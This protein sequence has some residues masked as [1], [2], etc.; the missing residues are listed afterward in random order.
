M[1]WLALAALLVAAPAAAQPTVELIAAPQAYVPIVI[2]GAT[3][4]ARVALGFDKALLL[5][6][7]PAQAARLK[8]FPVIGK[9]TIKNAL[10]PGGEAVARGNLYGARIAGRPKTTVPTVWIDKAI[11][12]EADGIVSVF[13]LDAERVTVRQPA[14]PAG[15]RTYTLTRDGKGDPAVKLRVGGE[16]LTVALDLV[17]PETIM[18]ARAAAALEAA[19]LVRRSGA[20]GLWTP[21]PNV[22]L[23]F[24]RLTPAPGATLAGLPLVRPAGRIT[25][26]RAKALD[27]AAQAGTSTVT[28][29]ADAITVTAKRERRRS[30]PWVLIGRDVLSRCSLIVLD[31]PGERW[32]LTCAF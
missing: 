8:A 30:D 5:N 1:I 15:G 18:N 16:T 19:G 6:L 21:F 32:L 26:A 23:P 12:A 10:I 22:R 28:D 29:D 13:A 2:K 31:R 25:E 14:A 20:V 9:R 7:A 17:S 11:A 3:V 4:R 24:E 27:A